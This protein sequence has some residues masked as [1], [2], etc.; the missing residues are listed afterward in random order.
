MCSL[1]DIFYLGAEDRVLAQLLAQ[2]ME[3]VTGWH[4]SDSI[5]NRLS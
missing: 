2:H 4:D 3:L 1:P 5:E